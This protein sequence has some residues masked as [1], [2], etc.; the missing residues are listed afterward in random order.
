M[1]RNIQ[2]FILPYF[3]HMSVRP[4]TYEYQDINKSRIINFDERKLLK[5][6]KDN[7]VLQRE[8]IKYNN[9]I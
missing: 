8:K 5:L 6:N 2:I 1:F 3:F 7:F 9:Y 4:T